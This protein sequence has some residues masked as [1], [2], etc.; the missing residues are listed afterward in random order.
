MRMELVT[1]LDLQIMGMALI[2]LDRQIML[3]EL[4]MKLEL[5]I[6]G[7]ELVIELE[8][9]IMGMIDINLGLQVI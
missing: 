4:A 2:D 7:M 3:M 1:E 9:Q 6:I 8:L 5:Q